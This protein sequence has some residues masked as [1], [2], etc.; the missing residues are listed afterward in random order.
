MF[1]AF[2]GCTTIPTGS[3]GV[4]GDTFVGRLSVR[5]D[6]TAA[7]PARALSAAFELRGDPRSGWLDLSTPLGSV[8][9]QARWSPSQVVLVTPRGE[10]TFASLDA[11]TAEVLGE[12]LPV[13]ALF[14]WLQGRPW[15]DAPVT[16]PATAMGGSFEQLGWA[17][18]LSRFDE[19][20]VSA[21]RDRSPAVDVR[22]KLER[23]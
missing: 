15:P 16:S 2:A 6:A 1:A 7:A 23:P 20:V 9:A 8:L 10:T 17:V 12:S 13:A 11:L 22:I 3:A 21:H 19:A 14:D 5:V 4:A 18:N